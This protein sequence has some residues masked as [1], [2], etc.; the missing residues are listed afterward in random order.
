[1]TQNP[2]WHYG[3]ADELL[4]LYNESWERLDG[5]RRS[6]LLAQAQGHATLAT[7]AV[8]LPAELPAAVPT[9]ST[10]AATQPKKH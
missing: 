8:G 7:V 5:A 3:K 9:Q 4:A 6:E 2:S 1:M 10:S